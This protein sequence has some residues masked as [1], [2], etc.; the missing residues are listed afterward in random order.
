VA[1]VIS[2]HRAVNVAKATIPEGWF[3][4]I[5]APG[6]PDQPY[7]FRLQVP[8][9]PHARFP[10]SYVFID[11]RTADIVAV[12]DV[13]SGDI[14]TRINTWVRPL[15]DGSVGG[16]PIRILAVL[17]GATPTVLAVTGILR[18][19]KRRMSRRMRLKA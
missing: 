3:V 8:S 9:D 4:F 18:W 13:R 14:G 17:V 19:R 1:R 16:L 15:H 5:D 12:Q 6:N 11:R 10:A 2:L 7:R